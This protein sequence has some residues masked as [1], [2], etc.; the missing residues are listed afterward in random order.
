MHRVPKSEIDNYLKDKDIP[1]VVG[2]R[3][4]LFK[5]GLTEAKKLAVSLW[6]S[7]CTLPGPLI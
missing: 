4:E 2:G 1:M 3:T 7:V 5:K 6:N